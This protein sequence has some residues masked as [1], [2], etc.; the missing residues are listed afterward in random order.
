MDPIRDVIDELG[1]VRS[2]IKTERICWGC[3]RC[4]SSKLNHRGG[5]EYCTSTTG[6]SLSPC[7]TLNNILLYSP[8]GLFTTA[9]W[10][11][12]TSIHRPKRDSVSWWMMFVLLL[13]TRLNDEML[14]WL[15][16]SVC[17]QV[18]SSVTGLGIA[19]EGHLKTGCDGPFIQE[20][21]NLTIFLKRIAKWWEKEER[22]ERSGGSKRENWMY[23]MVSESVWCERRRDRLFLF[24]SL[25]LLSSS[26]LLSHLLHSFAL[27]TEI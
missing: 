26:P 10:I 13:F 22:R 19:V 16:T 1:Q 2:I 25:S 7:L 24:L 18:T 23:E 11:F 3:L 21:G 14:P 17:W 6:F 20:S 9:I 15:S 12:R 5:I 27:Y 4:H 8:S